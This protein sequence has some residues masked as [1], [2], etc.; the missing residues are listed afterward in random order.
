[1]RS[2]V[3]MQGMQPELQLLSGEVLVNGAQLETF[4][5]ASLPMRPEERFAVLFAH[6]QLWAADDLEPY[7]ASMEVMLNAYPERSAC[8]MSPSPCLEN[9]PQRCETH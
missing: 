3:R 1:M 9:I 5:A 6:R 8:P 7:I 4:S 2:L